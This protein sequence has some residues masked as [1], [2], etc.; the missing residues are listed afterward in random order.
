MPVFCILFDVV[1]VVVV[2][3]I[4]VIAVAVVPLVTSGEATVVLKALSID[5]STRA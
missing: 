3:V 1:V 4:V 5:C 2:V